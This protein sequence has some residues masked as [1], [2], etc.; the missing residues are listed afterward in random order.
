MD[1]FSLAC[2]IP[3]FSMFFK[4]FLFPEENTSN[5]FGNMGF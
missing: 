4:K 5:F 3:I 2:T 1:I